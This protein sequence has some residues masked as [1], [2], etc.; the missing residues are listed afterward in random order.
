V[1]EAGAPRV[2]LAQVDAFFLALTLSHVTYFRS[3]HKTR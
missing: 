1:A 2:A 3:L